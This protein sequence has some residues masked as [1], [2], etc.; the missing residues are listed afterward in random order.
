[1]D[2][3]NPK[4]ELKKLEKSELVSLLCDMADLRKENLEWLNLKLEANEGM[5]NAVAY[6][7]GKIKACI[8]NGPMSDLRGARKLISNF[9]K[10]SKDKKEVIELMLFYVETGTRLGEEYG[11]LYSNFYTSMENMFHEIIELLKEPQNASL[12]EDVKPR[13]NWIVEHAAEG[14]GHRDILEDYLEELE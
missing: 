2:G 3:K 8:I 10:L 5:E 7:K 4:T 6:F 1:M 11:D 12:K 14:W 13:L 9:K